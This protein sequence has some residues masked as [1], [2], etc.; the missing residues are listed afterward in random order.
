MKKLLSIA[1][2]LV[3]SG[4]VVSKETYQTQYMA[5][6]ELEAKNEDLS[7]QLATQTE[8][9]KK[10]SVQ[11]DKLEAD[12][13]ALKLDKQRTEQA[14]TEVNQRLD[15]CQN[16]REELGT[17]LDVS[18]KSVRTAGMENDQLR[19]LMDKERKRLEAEISK[20]AAKI[21]ERDSSIEMLRSSLST[22]ETDRDVLNEQNEILE[23]EKQEKLI[24]MSKTYEGLLGSMED[25]IRQGRVTISRLKGQLTVNL[26]DEILFPSG[27]AQVKEEG[28]EVLARVGEALAGIED[29][30]IVIEG[31]TDNVPIIGGLA[32]KFPSNWELST[33]RAVSVVRYL[34]EEATLEPTR[35]S[36]VGYG[37][38][39]PV[40]EN[41]TDE[42]RAKNRRIEIK[43]MP[44]EPTP[45]P[46]DVQ[47]QVEQAEAVQ[48]E[49]PAE[50]EPETPAE[51]PE[52]QGATQPVEQDEAAAPSEVEQG[53]KTE[54][55]ASLDT[56]ESQPSEDA[57]V[58]KAEAGGAE[59][60][61][62]N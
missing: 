55:P 20:L 29:K 28:K 10:L 62:G 47:P 12:L 18:K 22:I 9:S 23:R 25:E 59:D 2:M 24:E 60:K 43:L 49:A 57:T 45:A 46:P 8:N 17:D 7:S 40:S 1:M 15:R 44:L 37:E 51:T 35:L 13:A 27:S 38:Y 36:A 41:D 26:V 33:A 56:G 52:P 6:R 39:H 54:V 19:E 30:T 4:C 31:H 16:T 48:G 32:Q 3:L 5:S 58:P 50:A 34:S 11:I 61:E 21:E 53:D 42:G 14:L